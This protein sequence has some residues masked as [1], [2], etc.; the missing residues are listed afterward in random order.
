MAPGHMTAFSH[1]L[2]MC[3]SKAREGGSNT[4][5]PKGFSVNVQRRESSLVKYSIPR[6]P[7]TRTLDVDLFADHWPATTITVRAIERI[8][9]SIRERKYRELVK[10]KG[11]ECPDL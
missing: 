1:R 6:L 11:K 9:T 3:N 5:C 7:I 10:D 2:E 4:L 8:H